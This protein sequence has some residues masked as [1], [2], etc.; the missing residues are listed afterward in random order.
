MA[1]FSGASRRAYI[2]QIGEISKEQIPET[3]PPLSGEGEAFR[4]W[5]WSP[6]GKWLAGIT[7]SAVGRS[8]GIVIYNLESQEYRKL[9][10]KGSS[11]VWLSD[12]RRVLFSGSQGEIKLV[13]SESGRVRE[14][15]SVSPDYAGGVCVS[16][17]NRS[18][19]FP[20]NIFEADI[21]MLTLN[22]DKQ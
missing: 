3:L 11:P 21:W 10:N 9:T 22:D 8:T 2:C 14:V 7:M 19:Y 20:L 1:Y 5:S 12:S 6:N 13:D 16:P 17:D 4:V 18:I 15:L